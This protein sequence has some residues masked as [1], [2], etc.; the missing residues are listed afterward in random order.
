[1]KT[2]IRK[3]KADDIYSLLALWS[4]NADVFV[5]ADGD[6]GQA[7]FEKWSQ[8]IKVSEA[9]NT[10]RSAKD[11]FFPQTEN[12]VGFRLEGKK[13]DIVDI[14]KDA[15]DFV[16]FGVRACDAKSFDIL[17]RVFLSQP[18]DTFYKNR[19]EHGTIVTLACS[20]AEDTCFCHTFGI[21]ATE[22]GGDVSAWRAG[23]ELYLRANTEKGEKLLA[24]SEKLLGAAEEI[25]KKTLET[26]K[27]ATKEMLAE[28]PLAGLTTEKF[29]GA[30]LLEKFRSEKWKELSAACL[31][32]GVCTF[33]CP[34]CQC[35]DIKEFN[36]GHGIRRFRCWDS[37]MYSDF[38]KM[39][40]ENPRHT[41]LE[42]FRQRFM[43]KLVYFPQN[44]EGIYGC[45]GCGRCLAKCPIS[46]NIV[47]V[48]KAVGED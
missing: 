40:A 33:V 9:V 24:A 38:T 26:Q 29:D 35:Y 32:C 30:N 23:D 7:R 22:P 18:V 48:M 19:R 47:K 42:R 8:G 28:L 46:M 14:R 11:F 12:L 36:T 25:D 45:V 1:M 34:T 20:A 13:I 2:E 41:Q 44:N 6:D 10:V 21:D 3:I 27:K 4:D 39:A 15:E 37:C 43:H 31:G 16:V 17:D 5:P